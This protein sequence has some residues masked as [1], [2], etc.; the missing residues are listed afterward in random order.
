LCFKENLTWASK[1]GIFRNAKEL[2]KSMTEAE[3][4]LW[5]QLRNKKL[6]G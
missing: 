1:P 5:N 2:R 3:E 4:L 6:N